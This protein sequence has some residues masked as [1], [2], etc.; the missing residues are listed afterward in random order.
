MSSHPPMEKTK[1]LVLTADPPRDL[2]APGGSIWIGGYVDG[3]I[4]DT[5]IDC[6]SGKHVKHI[7]SVPH[8]GHLSHPGPQTPRTRYPERRSG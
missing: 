7:S 3:C 2:V 5:Q 4:E 6:R 8:R 1:K